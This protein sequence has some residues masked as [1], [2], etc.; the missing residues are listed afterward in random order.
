VTALIRFS[1]PFNFTGSP[2]LSLPSGLT[3]DGL[4]LSLQL[5]GRHLDEAT[6]CRVG[7]AFEALDASPKRRPPH[8]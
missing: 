1:G 3:A 6:L 8:A 7:E 2:T 5:V 4:P